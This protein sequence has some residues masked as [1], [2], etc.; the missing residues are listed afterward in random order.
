VR[1]SLSCRQQCFK[2]ERICHSVVRVFSALV[3]SNLSTLFLGDWNI[4][5]LSRPAAFHPS[6]PPSFSFLPFSHS[7]Q[8]DNF[9]FATEYSSFKV[10][11]GTE[12]GLSGT[13]KPRIFVVRVSALAAAAA[14]VPRINSTQVAQKND[15]D[16]L[17]KLSRSLSVKGFTPRRF[18]ANLLPLQSGGIF[19]KPYEFNISASLYVCMHLYFCMNIEISTLGRGPGEL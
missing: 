14:V 3:K 17:K 2:P 19:R 13:Y 6:L 5:Y 11:N 8:G 10:F 15:L 16:Y 7:F 12:I 18:N 4:L 1:G 9:E